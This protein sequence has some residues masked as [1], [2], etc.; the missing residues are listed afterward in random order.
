MLDEN[1]IKNYRESVKILLDEQAEN[2]YYMKTYGRLKY[3]KSNGYTKE[4]IEQAERFSILYKEIE[5][6][7]RSLS[8]K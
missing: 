4:E 8:G 3:A 7:N 5:D 6:Y 1:Q 2:D